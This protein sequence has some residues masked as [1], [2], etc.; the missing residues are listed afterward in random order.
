MDDGI[1]DSKLNMETVDEAA[2]DGV[3]RPVKDKHAVA[4]Q[5]M[6]Q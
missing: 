4:T 3:G 2:E 6:F 1:V 5:N